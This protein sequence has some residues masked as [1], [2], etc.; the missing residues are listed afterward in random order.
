MVAWC[1]QLGALAVGV[2]AP[3]RW[4]LTGRAR[5]AESALAAEG[6]RCFATPSRTAAQGRAFYRWMVNGAVLFRVLEANYP[7][8]DGSNASQG[9][10]CFE[11]FPRA[12]ACALAAAGGIRVAR[13]DLGAGIPIACMAVTQKEPMRSASRRGKPVITAT[14]MLESMTEHR[15][16]T[17]AEAMDVANAI[18]DGSGAV[19]LS[20]ESAV[21]RY[22]VE[23]VEML[24]DIAAASEPHRARTT[25][26][27]LSF[28][29]RLPTSSPEACPSARAASRPWL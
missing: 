22:P 27:C 1:G 14:Q 16:P 19:M 20:A 29:D 23:A 26:D 6:I 5:S 8:F 10:V 9:S 15:R 3:C 28:Q 24:A 18:L 13:G 2:D 21:G 11:S 4:S 12:V 7:L 17:R 25:P